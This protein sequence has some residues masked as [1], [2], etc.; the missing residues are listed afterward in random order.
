MSE[1]ALPSI[2]IVIPCYNSSRTIESVVDAI[3]TVMDGSVISYAYDIIL[4]NDGSPDNTMDVISAIALSSDNIKAIDLT[5][6]FGQHSATIAGF[7]FCTGDYVVLM[8][9]DGEHDSSRIFDLIAELE[10]GYDYVCARFVSSERPLYKKLGS[11]FNNWM[12]TKFIGKPKGAVFSSFSVMRRFLAD[13]I[14]KT[15]NPSPYIGGMIVAVTKRLSS[16]PVEYATRIDGQSGYNFRKSVALWVNGITAFSTK[17][18]R[19]AAYAGLFL[20]VIGMLS[21]AAIVIQKLLNPDIVAGYTSLIS[22]LLFIGGV[23]MVIMGLMGE[24]VSRLYLLANA[25]P[26]YA[27]RAVVQKEN[28]SSTISASKE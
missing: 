8:D 21:G 18:L 26:Q 15:P 23:L 14:A 19:Y 9:D 20:A 6:N 7:S 1:N 24:Y 5:R 13:E 10:R 17:P 28:K 4:V 3:K 25:I 2:S 16:V 27:I 12:A 22:A 11:R